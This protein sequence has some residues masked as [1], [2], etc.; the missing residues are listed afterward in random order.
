MNIGWDQNYRSRD[1]MFKNDISLL[2][3]EKKQRLNNTKLLF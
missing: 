1:I 2:F 3:M